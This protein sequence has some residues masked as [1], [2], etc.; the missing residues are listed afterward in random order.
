MRRKGK[1]KGKKRE[2]EMLFFSYIFSLFHLVY[3][4]SL[5]QETIYILF[6]KSLKESKEKRAVFLIF[7]Q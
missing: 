6:F 1:E 3:F 5:N 7:L 2:R 4:V